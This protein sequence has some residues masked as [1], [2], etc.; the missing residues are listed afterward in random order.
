MYLKQGRWDEA[1]KLFVQ[2]TET[3]KTKLGADHPDTLTSI[4]DLAS[5]YRNQGRL[6]EAE[7]LDMQVRKTRR[8]IL[9]SGHLN[10]LEVSSEPAEYD[11][12]VEFGDTDSSSDNDSVFSVPAS[13]PSTSSFDSGRGEM[14]LLL[15]HQFSKLLNEDGDLL[16]LLLIGVS[17]E[18]IGFERMRNNFRRLLKHFANDL[19]ADIL[20]E[21]H[22]DL[23]RFVSSY[24][25]MITRKLFSM[26]FI[27]EQP[28]LNPDE[29]LA[30]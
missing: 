24:S 22:R 12:H 4:G 17:R 21:S 28:K 16:S 13:I 15:I 7:Q 30:I 1:E 10:V 29:D 11:R 5:T 18:P 3:R 8:Q 6:E 20:S 25:V 14:N 26:V 19:K 9:G 23:M 2:V 27:D